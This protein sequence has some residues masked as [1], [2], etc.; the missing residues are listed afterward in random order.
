MSNTYPTNTVIFL[1]KLVHLTI[2]FKEQTTAE[3]SFLFYF[4]INKILSFKRLS[5]FQVNTVGLLIQWQPRTFSCHSQTGN[6]LFQSLLPLYQS[7]WNT[8]S[9]IHIQRLNFHTLCMYFF[10]LEWHT[11]TVP[12][13]FI[14]DHRPSTVC[15][16]SYQLQIDNPHH[17]LPQWLVLLFS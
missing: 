11:C 17:W 9:V 3:Q 14:S 12:W 5:A 8:I 16:W 13:T 15:C 7:F 10:S 2:P 1:D 4:N 6:F